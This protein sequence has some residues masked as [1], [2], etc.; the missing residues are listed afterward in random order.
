MSSGIYVLGSISH[1]GS[2]F[3]MKVAGNHINTNM[4]HN[5]NTYQIN[6]STIRVLRIDKNSLFKNSFL[7]YIW[8]NNLIGVGQYAYPFSFYIP[9]DLPVNFE[10]YDADCTAYVK[11]I[12]MAKTLSWDIL[13]DIIFT[14]YY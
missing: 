6:L 7:I 9:H 10:H 5:M 1:H 8:N 11:Y 13:N 14:S 2:G 3:S 12:V 4:N